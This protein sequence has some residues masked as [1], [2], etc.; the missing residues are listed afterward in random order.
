LKRRGRVIEILVLKAIASF[1]LLENEKAQDLLEGALSFAEPQGYLRMF[2]D[3][4]EPFRELL[5]SLFED[6]RRREESDS[7]GV[8]VEYLN[9]LLTALTTDSVARK[10]AG[11]GEMEPFS[12]RELEVLRYLTT[13]LTSTEI[14]QELYIS[15]NTVR[16]HIKNIYSKLGVNQR[17]AAV[18]RA[19]DLGLV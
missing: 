18:E 14:A 13:S 8:S 7:A 1:K 2:I 19:R 12:D 9:Q 5:T 16:F 6:V 17:A 3:E 4:G 15:P 10:I 11:Q